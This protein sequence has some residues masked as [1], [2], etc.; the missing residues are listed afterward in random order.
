MII[1]RGMTRQVAGDEMTVLIDRG[2]PARAEDITRVIGEDRRIQA[3]EQVPRERPVREPHRVLEAAAPVGAERIR[4]LADPG[5]DESATAER[6]ALIPAQMP[7][8]RQRHELE[9]PVDF[10]QVLDVA[11]VPWIAVV[12]AL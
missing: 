12:E 9:V 5:I 11:D 2:E 7:R 4:A 8:L 3:D 6:I 10:P 1:R